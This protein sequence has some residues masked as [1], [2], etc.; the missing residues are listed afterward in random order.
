[1]RES[2]IVTSELENLDVSE[3]AT[4]HIWST[5]DTSHSS[6]CIWIISD[7]PSE[8]GTCFFIDIYQIELGHSTRKSIWAITD[9]LIIIIISYIS[10]SIFITDESSIRRTI[11]III[12]ELYDI[13]TVSLIS[14]RIGS[15][16]QSCNIR[17][18]IRCI[19]I[20]ETSTGSHS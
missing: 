7:G 10:I 14:S 12:F 20:R 15:I 5:I 2:D 11:L 3:A 1:M 9:I 17:E 6:G 8:K 13:L 19:E 4:T 18:R 16:I